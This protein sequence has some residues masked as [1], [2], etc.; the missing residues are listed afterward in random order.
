MSKSL[1]LR[2]AVGAALIA[3]A[4]LV[5]LHP[6]PAL[7]QAASEP[8]ATQEAAPAAPTQEAAALPAAPAP[9]EAVVE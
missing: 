9:L 1:S 2:A 7:A 3:T 6:V 5:G 8:A 4:A